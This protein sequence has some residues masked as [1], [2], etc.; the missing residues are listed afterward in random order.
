MALSTGINFVI[1]SVVFL[2]FSHCLGSRSLSLTE[3]ITSANRGKRLSN[4]IIIIIYYWQWHCGLYKFVYIPYFIMH[5]RY[6]Y[7]AMLSVRDIISISHKFDSFQVVLP[8]I[9][10]SIFS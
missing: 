3:N 4:L 2:A 7:A 10:D 8:A 5:S 6:Y 1:I 9:W